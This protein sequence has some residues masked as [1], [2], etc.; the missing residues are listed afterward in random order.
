METSY[1]NSYYTRYPT[2]CQVVWI[3]GVMC[4]GGPQMPGVAFVEASKPTLV[5]GAYV[6]H[7]PTA[8]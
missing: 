4:L 2:I 7:G 6:I 8:G 5:R 1:V 3:S